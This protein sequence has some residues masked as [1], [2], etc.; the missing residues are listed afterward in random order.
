MWYKQL[1]KQY[2]KLYSF[3]DGWYIIELFDSIAL[4]RECDDIKTFNAYNLV[5]EDLSCLRGN[6]NKRKVILTH[7]GDTGDS[8]AETKREDDQ[9]GDEF[10]GYTG[11]K[12][13]NACNI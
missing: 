9:N 5:N 8:S 2:E 1:K 10:I 7:Q 4:Q 6:D 3:S 13:V 11:G 12:R